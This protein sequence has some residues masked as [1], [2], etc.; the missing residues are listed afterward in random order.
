MQLIS[1][2]KLIFFV[3][4]VII[5]VILLLYLILRRRK[6]KLDAEVE[7]LRSKQRI[8]DAKKAF[9]PVPPPASASPNPVSVRPS[10]SENAVPQEEPEIRVPQ[11]INGARMVY[12]YDDV[13]V[14][15]YSDSVF[16]ADWI[17]AHA[18]LRMQLAS[19][20]GSKEV[21]VTM[22]GNPFAY[23]EDNKLLDMAYDWLVREDPYFLALRYFSSQEK[24]IEIFMAYYRKRQRSSGGREYKLVSNRNSEMQE[25]ISLCSEGSECYFSFDYDKE[26]Y[27]VSCMTFDIGYLPKSAANLV[28]QFGEDNVSV[29][30]SSIDY[31]ENDKAVV[32]VTVES[33]KAGE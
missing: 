17:S 3:V 16:E 23:L 27:L 18:P 25:N 9:S 29:F 6:V 26:K 1:S 15:P 20:R 30:V 13:H 22:D 11:Q 12:H 14:V 33:Q 24:K 31:D 21:L 19:D 32:T 2:E 8:E 10:D 5:A 4:V 7:A 28:E